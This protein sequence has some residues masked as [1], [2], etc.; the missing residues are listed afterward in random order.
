MKHKNKGAFIIELTMGLLFMAGIS[1]T[2]VNNMI[3][4]NYRGQ[5][6]RLSYSLATVLSERKQLFGEKKN[7][8]DTDCE[9]FVSDIYLLT[10]SSM[11]RMNSSFDESRLKIRIE[12]LSIIVNDDSPSNNVY[13]L[14]RLVYEEGSSNNCELPDTSDITHEEIINFLP[15]TNQKNYLPMYQVS[16]CYETPFNIMG[17]GNNEVTYIKSSSFSFARI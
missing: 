5:L 17:I 10:S 11:R 9:S 12:Q 16:L 15:I 4:V 8:C 14:H 2:I 13:E 6:D 3:A 7:I 1:L